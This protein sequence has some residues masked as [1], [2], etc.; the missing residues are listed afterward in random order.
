M[1]M[2]RILFPT[3][4]SDVSNNAFVY[5]LR[6]ADTLHAAILTLHVYDLPVIDNEGFPNYLLEMYDVLEVGQFENY[7]GQVPVLRDIADKHGLSHIPLS[8][9]LLMG[10]LVDNIKELCR[11]EAIEYV[12]MGTK[13]ASGLKETFLGSTASNVIAG[14]DAIVLAIPEHCQYRPIRNIVFTSRFKEK[15]RAALQQVLTIADGFA[16]KVHCLYVRTPHSDVK[17]VIIRD[18]EHV[19]GA[20]GVLFHIIESDHVK[21]AILAFTQAEKADLLAMLHFKRSFL[22]ELFQHSL[23][24]KIAHHIQIPILALHE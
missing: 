17:E 23:T 2:K 16:A 9:E 18:W 7:K 8:H 5:A 15:D 12:V 6:L 10:D 20:Q 24:Q 22:E 1:T 14:T 3:D 19:F 21:E 4:F 11:R 13:G